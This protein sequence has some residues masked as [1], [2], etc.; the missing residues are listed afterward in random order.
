MKR[1]LCLLLSAFAFIA[2]SPGMAS[3]HLLKGQYANNYAT[4]VTSVAPAVPLLTATATSDG[5]S[6]S[7]A[8]TGTQTVIV[9]GYFHE[10]YLRITPAGVDEN[11]NSPSVD[12]NQSQNIGSLGDGSGINKT[13]VWKHISDTRVA[14]WH[15]HRVH[16]MG[17]DPPPVA[18]RDP[19]VDH[20]I[21][22]WKL[23]LLV[24]STPVVVN[25][26]LTWLKWSAG[27]KLPLVL[28]VS[29]TVVVIGIAV[30][31]VRRRRKAAVAV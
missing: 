22:T 2:L 31:L 14:T 10:P 6:V 4:A 12:L 15:D 30:L 8:Y 5:A 27:S 17:S 1:L 11:T 3:A 9:Y 7:I 26:T 21:E 24:G 23:D 25:G 28:G 29:V 16:W 18:Q 19:G 13:P 20:L